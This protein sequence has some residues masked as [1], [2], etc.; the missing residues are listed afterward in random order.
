MTYVLYTPW[1]AQAVVFKVTMPAIIGSIKLYLK[2]VK[3]DIWLTNEPAYFHLP[4]KENDCAIIAIFCLG[5][6]A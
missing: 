6:S 4:G 3:L 2:F 1:L 5:E